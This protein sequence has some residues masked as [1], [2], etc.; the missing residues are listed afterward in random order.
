MTLHRFFSQ[1]VV[2]LSRISAFFQQTQSLHHARFASLH[3]LAGL[4]THT[5][6]EPGLLLGASRFNQIL[7]VH[8]TKTRREL[9]NTLVVAPPRSGKSV[10]A[11]SSY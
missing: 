4:L 10:L 3:E 2:F 6:D 8:P 11:V 1:V 9:G 7:R 5:F